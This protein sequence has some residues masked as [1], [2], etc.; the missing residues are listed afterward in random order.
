MAATSIVP[1][2]N[3]CSPRELFESP[4]CSF[5]NSVLL[6]A[7]VAF[8]FLVTFCLGYNY[9]VYFEAQRRIWER[10]D[11]QRDEEVWSQ[12][13]SVFQ[14]A[15]TSFS[16]GP[17]SIRDRLVGSDDTRPPSAFERWHFTATRAHEHCK[18]CVEQHSAASTPTTTATSTASTF[19]SDES[20]YMA[21]PGSRENVPEKRC[22]TRARRPLL[23]SDPRNADNIRRTELRR[24]GDRGGPT[25]VVGDI[26]RGTIAQRRANP[27]D[28]LYVDQ[29]MWVS[30]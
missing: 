22:R 26:Q 16:D 14:P 7:V 23:R 10:H 15:P 24:R 9:C 4:F 21:D 27:T 1:S 8:V 25:I 2:K 5:L 19:E 28:V 20:L 11:H 29:D 13:A 12:L 30:A 6:L 18:R 3:H 17:P